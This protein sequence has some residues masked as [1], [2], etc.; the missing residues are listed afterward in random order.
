MKQINTQFK[1]ATQLE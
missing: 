1:P